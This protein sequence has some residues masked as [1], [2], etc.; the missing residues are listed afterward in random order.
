MKSGGSFYP[1]GHNKIT[2]I[3]FVDDNVLALSTDDNSVRS[4]INYL[5]DIDRSNFSY[6][7]VNKNNK[8]TSVGVH[9]QCRQWLHARYQAETSSMF[10]RRVEALPSDRELHGTCGRH[11]RGPLEENCRAGQ[12]GERQFEGTSI[13]MIY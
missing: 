7:G 4:Q 11:Q 8:Y 5:Y 9:L 10:Y 12:R 3:K 6:C 1:I 2:C 13:G